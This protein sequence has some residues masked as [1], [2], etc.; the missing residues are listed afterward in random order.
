VLAMH[1]LSGTIFL[2]GIIPAVPALR[3]SLRPPPAPYPRTP[4]IKYR[5]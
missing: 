5:V 3:G 1:F 2:K 4:R